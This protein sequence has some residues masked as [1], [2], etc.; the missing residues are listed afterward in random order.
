MLLLLLGLAQATPLSP[1]A[2]VAAALSSNPSLAR[3]EAELNAARGAAR[4]S[5]LFRENP[6]IQ[7][8]YGLVGGRFDISLEQPLSLTGEGLAD[9]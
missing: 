9:H 6:E 2:A 1:D 8:G 7:A 3:A 5:A 4:Q